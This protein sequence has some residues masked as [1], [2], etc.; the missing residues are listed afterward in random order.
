MRKKSK[1]KSELSDT[2][3]LRLLCTFSETEL[4]ALGDFVQSPFFNKRTEVVRLL[5]HLLPALKKGRPLP[6]RVAL[7]QKVFGMKYVI[8]C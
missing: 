7:Y 5:E 8:P 1:P 6:D 4:E 3:L 2:R